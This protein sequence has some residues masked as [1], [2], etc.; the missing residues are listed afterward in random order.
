MKR[1]ILKYTL[2]IGLGPVIM[3]CSDFLEKTSPSEILADEWF[4][5]ENSLVTYA[6]GFLNSY[7]PSVASLTYGD[8]DA[9]YVARISQSSF[10][11]DS[12]TPNDQTG[13]SNSDWKGIYNVNYFS[14]SL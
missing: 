9:D 10:F 5:N 7:T 6:N 3:S 12:W 8:G 14:Q 4:Y 13:W 2:L 1:N 11:T